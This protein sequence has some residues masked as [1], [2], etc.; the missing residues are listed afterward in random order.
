MKFLCIV[1]KLAGEG[2]VAVSVGIGDRGRVKQGLFFFVLL[3]CFGIFLV[4]VLL[5]A[6]T[7][8]SGP[9]Q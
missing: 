4:L 6:L 8:T 2:S 1:G 5:S 3:T 7:W 9:G